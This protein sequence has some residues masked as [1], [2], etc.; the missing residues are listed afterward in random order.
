VDLELIPLTMA[1]GV[2]LSMQAHGPDGTAIEP[3]IQK[4]VAVV[5][6][7]PEEGF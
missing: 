3:A 1:I 5:A 2:V 4:P 7:F 6:A